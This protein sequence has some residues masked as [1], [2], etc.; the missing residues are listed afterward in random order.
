MTY[1]REMKQREQNTR[2]DPPLVDAKKKGGKKKEQTLTLAGSKTE[3]Q[4]TDVVK[5]D[6]SGYNANGRGGVSR[7]HTESTKERR[8]E[9]QRVGMFGRDPW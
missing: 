2:A 3:T 9:C 6:Y 5:E 7:M 8:R 4:N 1:M